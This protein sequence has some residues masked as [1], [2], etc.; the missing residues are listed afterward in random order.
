MNTSKNGFTVIEILMIIVCI[1]L[2]VSVGRL[3]YDRF[4]N[5]TSTQQVSTELDQQ[6]DKT[7]QANPEVTSKWKTF[8]NSRLPFSFSY[9]ENWTA[10]VFEDASYDIYNISVSAPGTH[11]GDSV[12][13]DI[14]KGAKISLDC[15]SDGSFVSLE[16]FKKED[17]IYKNASSKKREVTV[18]N[19]TALQ[20]VVSYEGPA[21]RE[22]TFFVNKNQCDILI[23]ESI[24]ENKIYGK[25]YDELLNSVRF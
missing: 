15:T 2:V 11:R 12:Y 18:N 25:L 3:A 8:T 19:T 21:K 5:K 4:Y 13:E 20:Y 17:Y 16:Q 7:A 6:Q 10:E 24:Y 14:V 9:P 22:T 23:Q 1:G